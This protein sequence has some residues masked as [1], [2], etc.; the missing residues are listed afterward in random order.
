M[1]KQNKRTNN[2]T[3]R[4]VNGGN[5]QI[6]KNSINIVNKFLKGLKKVKLTQTEINKLNAKVYLEYRPAVSKRNPTKKQIR[7]RRTA[8]KSKTGITRN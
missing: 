1:D 7:N 2:I 4:T 3:K 6:L 5:V 8:V